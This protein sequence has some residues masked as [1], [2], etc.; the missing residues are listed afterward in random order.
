[1]RPYHLCHF[2]TPLTIKKIF[3]EKQPILIQKNRCLEVN[4]YAKTNLEQGTKLDGIGGYH[5]YGVLGKPSGLPI[6]LAKRATLINKKRK[7]EMIEW[8][9][10]TFMENDPLLTLWKQQENC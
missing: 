10:V 4:A 8:A 2:E 5:L 9:D 6:G 7:D 1:M 3:A